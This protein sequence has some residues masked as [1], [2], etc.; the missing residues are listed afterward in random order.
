LRREAGVVWPAERLWRKTEYAARPGAGPGRGG[1]P[2]RRWLAA[3]WKRHELVFL[4]FALV[5]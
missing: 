3:S 5:F 2:R 4:C 1:A